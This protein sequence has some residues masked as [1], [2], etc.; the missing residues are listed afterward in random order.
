[1]MSKSPGHIYVIYRVTMDIAI[2]EQPPKPHGLATLGHWEVAEA[3]LLG[4]TETLLSTR[5]MVW[6]SATSSWEEAPADQPQVDL[7][8]AGARYIASLKADT[9]SLEAKVVELEGEKL[10]QSLKADTVSLGEAQG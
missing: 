9:V 1:M 6:N 8:A 7:T 10:L 2:S 5:E 4:W 3:D